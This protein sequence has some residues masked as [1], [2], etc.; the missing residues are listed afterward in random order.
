MFTGVK[1][2]LASGILLASLGGCA[3]PQINTASPALQTSAA[4]FSVSRE[5]MPPGVVPGWS[6][7]P[8]VGFVQATTGSLALGVALPLI[9]AAANAAYVHSVTQE[10]ASK[11]GVLTTLELPALLQSGLQADDQTR[12][13]NWADASGTSGRYVLTPSLLLSLKEGDKD[14]IAV[15]TLNV[16]QM[17]GAPQPVWQSNYTMHIDQI[18]DYEQVAASGGVKEKQQLEQQLQKAYAQLF[19]VFRAHAAGEYGAPSQDR[20]QIEYRGA[21]SGAMYQGVLLKQSDEHLI[22]A[23]YGGIMS[24]PAKDVVVRKI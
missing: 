19:A 5:A 23:T 9:G 12:S 17:D 21:F 3:A 14:L 11:L 10:K 24:I 6:I 4:T 20:V 1:R 15:A 13:L 7:A 18:T 2:F 16:R 8:N 22:L